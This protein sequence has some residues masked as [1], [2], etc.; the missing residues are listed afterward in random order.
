MPLVWASRL[1]GTPLP[2]RVAASELIYPLAERA[3]ERGHTFYLLGAADGVAERAAA[4]LAERV[5]GLTIAGVHSPPV[6]FES[7]HD[8]TDAVLADLA[9]TRPAIV[10]C[11]FGFPKQERLM[12][13]LTRR[14]PTTWFIGVGGTLTMAAGVTP[15]APRWMRRSGLEWLHR[16]ALEPRRLFRRYVVH[17]GPF[18]FRLLASSARQRRGRRRGR[19]RRGETASGHSSGG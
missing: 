18:A 17:D 3:A 19:G 13:V 9:R 12:A 2:E 4:V 10:L 7:S 6:G 11:A 16:L 15:H 8:A 1:Q 14:F 5:P